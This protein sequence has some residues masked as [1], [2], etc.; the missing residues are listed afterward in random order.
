MTNVHDVHQPD[1]TNV[2]IEHEKTIMIAYIVNIQFTV[3]G[4]YMK[5]AKKQKT[6]IV[7][8]LEGIGLSQNEAFLYEH[9]LSHQ[10]HTIQ[11]LSMQ[12]P[13]PR[14]L[15]YHILKQLTERSLVVQSPA[16]GKTQYILESPDRISELLAKRQAQFCNTFDT[17]RAL[18]PRMKHLHKLSGSRPFVRTFDGVE[19]YKQLLDGV[20]V[21][22][23]KIIRAYN[24]P[25]APRYQNDVYADFERARVAKKIIKQNL[26]FHTDGAL[27][28][29]KSVPYNDYTQWRSVEQSLRVQTFT[30]Q[31]IMY[32]DTTIY[33]T[34]LGHE[35]TGVLMQDE[36]LT[37]MHLSQFEYLWQHGKDR[38]LYLHEKNI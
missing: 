38:T 19:N 26:F 37:A 22:K 13:F 5:Y 20:I 9:M 14:T 12:T 11:A 21:E 15:L 36:S 32:G 24:I 17:V 29:L 6:P 4:A 30:A 35:P 8:A 34:W 10:T 1:S 25:C 16:K 18:V 23:P 28:S 3:Y 2:N 7:L 33:T 31:I 27:K